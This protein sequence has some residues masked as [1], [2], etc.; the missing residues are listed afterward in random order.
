MLRS[1]LNAECWLT[2]RWPDCWHRHLLKK[3]GRLS[4]CLSVCLSCVVEFSVPLIPSREFSLN[5]VHLG[6]PTDT[7]GCGEKWFNWLEKDFL[8]FCFKK[9]SEP[10]ESESERRKSRLFS[11]WFSRLDLHTHL[12]FLISSELNHSCL[13]RGHIKGLVC[14]TILPPSAFF[15]RAIMPPV[16][17]ILIQKK[18]I[19]SPRSKFCQLFSMSKV[20]PRTAW[21]RKPDPSYLWPSWLLL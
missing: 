3:M 21:S 17:S 18:I 14:G 9:A 6:R 19:S 20:V 12:F 11:Q 15:R 13:L 2:A 4:V 1:M 16:H 8:S 5:W 7:T 10:R